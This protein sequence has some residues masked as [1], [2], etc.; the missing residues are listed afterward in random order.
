MANISLTLS[1]F[2]FSPPQSTTQMGSLSKKK[3]VTNMSR[4]GTFKYYVSRYAKRKRCEPTI[5]VRK[6]ITVISLA[7]LM[8]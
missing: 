3:S 2:W 8:L 6:Q 5:F 4:L 1:I 7:L